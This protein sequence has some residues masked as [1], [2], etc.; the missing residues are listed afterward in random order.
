M[1]TKQHQA[2]QFSLETYNLH[3]RGLRHSESRVSEGLLGYGLS[4]IEKTKQVYMSK[5]THF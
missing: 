1:N 2:I 4:K 5:I 3:S